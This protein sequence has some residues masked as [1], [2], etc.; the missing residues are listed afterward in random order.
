[1]HVQGL[2]GCGHPLFQTKLGA[3]INHAG[4]FQ[5]GWASSGGNCRIMMLLALM[6]H[7]TFALKTAG[8]QAGSTKGLR[9]QPHLMTPDHPQ[10]HTPP[11]IKTHAVKKCSAGP[12]Q[13]VLCVSRME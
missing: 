2:A 11:Q 8:S 1:V 10:V 12:A 13:E 5:A 9:P 4:H 6:P 3:Y 7:Q